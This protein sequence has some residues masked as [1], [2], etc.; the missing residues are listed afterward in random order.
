[1]FVILTLGTADVFFNGAGLIQSQSHSLI[2]VIDSAN[3]LTIQNIALS[4]T[5]ANSTLAVVTKGN[6]GTFTLGGVTDAGTVGRIIASKGK[7]TGN[8]GNVNVDLGGLSV[9]L[10]LQTTN[11]IIDVGSGVAAGPA[12]VL[13]SVTDSSLNAT[14][15]VRLIKAV[16]WLNT[17][18]GN[19]E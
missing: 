7:L 13:G 15:A 4:G 12:F 6:A 11:S 17:G 8:V 19:L 10:V 14:G 9:M 5:N 18:N 3:N 2:T 1:P 16:N